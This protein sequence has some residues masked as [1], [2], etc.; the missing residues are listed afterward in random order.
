M[1]GVMLPM[2]TSFS[3]SMEELG[4]PHSEIQVIKPTRRR[5]LLYLL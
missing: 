2:N 1:H 4:L 3:V 5:L